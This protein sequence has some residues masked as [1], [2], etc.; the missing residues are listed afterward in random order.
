MAGRDLAGLVVS[1]GGSKVALPSIT[2]GKSASARFKVPDFTNGSAI[3]VYDP[4]TKK[5]YFAVGFFEG[6]LAG[7]VEVHVDSIALDG[8]L[9]GRVYDASSHVSAPRW[10][11][12]KP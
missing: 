8:T 10:Q 9:T 4:A 11:E 3:V 7:R 6:T 1:D 2:S 5:N 12:L